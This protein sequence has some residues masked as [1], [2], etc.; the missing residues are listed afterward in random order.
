[1]HLLK[2]FGS[3]GGAANSSKPGQS[4]AGG[5]PNYFSSLNLA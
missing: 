3:G 5:K 4:T 2:N 1:M